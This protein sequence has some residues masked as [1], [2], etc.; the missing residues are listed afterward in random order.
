MINSLAWETITNYYPNDPRKHCILNDSTTKDE[1][2]KVEAC[3]Q[4]LEA[5]L[6]VRPTVGKVKTFMI[7]EKPS[8]DEE[9]ASKVELE[10]LPSSLRNGFLGH[11][12][13]YLVI[14]SE[15]LSAS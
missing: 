14:V 7:D 3:A 2:P 4:F 5:S 1:N 13:T 15:C 11:N 12:S 6:E 8:F 9:R 10:P